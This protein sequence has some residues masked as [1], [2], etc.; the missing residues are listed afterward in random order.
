MLIIAAAFNESSYTVQFWKISPMRFRS[1]RQSLRYGRP[2]SCKVLTVPLKSCRVAWQAWQ[3]CCQLFSPCVFLAT[4]PG[5]ITTPATS[6][7]VSNKFLKP[8]S[9]TPP[10]V[11]HSFYCSEL[12]RKSL[13]K[14]CSTYT[15]LT[16]EIDRH[17]EIMTTVGA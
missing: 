17:E 4:L 2:T 8:S 7:A 9:F 12:G 3:V 14:V 11:H 13:Y 15:P 5:K 6:Y 10:G 1:T 16:I